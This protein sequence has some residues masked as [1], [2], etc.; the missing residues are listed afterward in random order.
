MLESARMWLRSGIFV[1]FWGLACCKLDS[2]AD[3]DSADA[4][5]DDSSEHIGAGITQIQHRPYAGSLLKNNTYVC[6]TV[7]LNSYWLITLSKCFDS[8]IISSHVSHK[9]LANFSVRVGSSYNN[10]G[11]SLYKIKMLI[12]NFDLK[13]SAVKLEAPLEFGSRV[14]AAQLAKPDEEVELG[15]LASMIAWTPT[16][17]IRV[18][19][20]PIIE[21]SICD[22]NT[23]LLPGHYICVGGVQD[24]NRHF[25]RQDN[26]GAVIQNETLIA[27]SSFLQPCAVYTKTHAFPKVSSFAR[28]L[29]SVIW[30][31]GNRPIT[32]AAPTTTQTTKPPNTTES[33]TGL[34]PYFADPSKFLLTLPFD[35]IN[36]PL[37]PAEDNSVI[38]RM[39]LY[40]SYL[41]NMARAKTS[42]THDPNAEDERREWLKKFGKK[43]PIFM[44]KKYAQYDYS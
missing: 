6:S 30:D 28:W 5:L 43:M 36:V 26:G 11:G 31:E 12:N 32:T 2:T 17:H 25:C 19:N 44:P 42:T 37:E 22:D 41:Q 39:S 13:V 38:P 20:A 14:Q 34:N 24:L 15:Y 18:V 21:A 35:P 9:N 10:K 29:D 33:S 8:D 1:C 27:I 3:N 16:S 4:D 23:K 7:I 40:E